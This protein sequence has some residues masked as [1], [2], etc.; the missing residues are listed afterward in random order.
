MPLYSKVGENEGIE[1][2]CI[3]H[4]RKGRNGRGV[5]GKGC[6]TRGKELEVY[7]LM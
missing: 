7:D 2:G 5:E 4:V 3:M 1:G 6:E